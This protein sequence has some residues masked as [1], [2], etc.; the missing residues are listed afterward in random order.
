[1]AVVGRRS[2]R[3]GHRSLGQTEREAPPPPHPGRPASQ[4]ACRPARHAAPLR[5]QRPA[6]CT[7]SPV[8]FLAAIPRPFAFRMRATTPAVTAASNPF[9]PARQQRPA[10]TS[11]SSLTPHHHHCRICPLYL[12]HSRPA[13]ICSAP[14]VRMQP[15]VGELRPIQRYYRPRGAHRQVLSCLG[16][17]R[18]G[19]GPDQSRCHATHDDRRAPGLLRAQRHPLPQLEPRRRR[20]AGGAVPR[21]GRAA[22]HEAREVRARN[23]GDLARHRPPRRHER[24]LDREQ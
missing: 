21:E 22:L 18:G 14:H 2:F 7:G 19:R 6:T 12:G 13:P 9:Q 16:R 24:V 23:R 10:S 5:T 15:C 11:H 8:A 3:H 4:R 17:L 1:M 20:R